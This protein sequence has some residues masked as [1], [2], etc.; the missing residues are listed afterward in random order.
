LELEIVKQLAEAELAKQN[1]FD[2][3]FKFDNSK[4]RF[5]LCSFSTKTI[6]LS[7]TLALLNSEIDIIDTIK[8]E[9][10]HAIVGSGNGHNH[11]WKKK[12]VELGC[13][14]KRC[15]E[16]KFVQ[17]PKGIYIYECSNCK[18]RIE[19]FKQS[20]KDCACATCCRK[21]N[22]NKWSN[23]YLLKLVEVNR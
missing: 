7:R 3:K 14:E 5:G 16:S 20:Q 6:S 17:K 10:A 1:L 19:R 23:K 12:A 13:S 4:R 21:F 18:Q 22:N 11:I 2:W 9:V 8:H 15:Y